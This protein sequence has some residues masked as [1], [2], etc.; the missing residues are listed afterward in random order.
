MK[1]IRLM[2]A[3]LVAV[4]M[5]SSF[6]LADVVTTANVNLRSGPGVSYDIIATIEPDVRL[7][8]LGE[9]CGNDNIADWYNVDY[10]GLAGWISAKYA[11]IVEDREPVILIPS[12][13]VTAEP[14]TQMEVSVFWNQG[15]SAAAKYVGLAGYQETLGELTKKYFN[16]YLTF[17]GNEKVQYIGLFGRGYTLF[18]ASVGMEI[19]DAAMALNAAGLDLLSVDEA[20]IVFGHRADN[21]SGVNVNGHDS[22]V[23]LNMKNGFVTEIEWS[24][25][26]G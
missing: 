14:L 3:L 24:A 21:T 5:V 25:Y 19:S 15:L 16:A 22:S 9:D 13:S 6:A 10:N 20:S 12:E 18:G 1:K 7:R 2:A 8:Y 11:E 4:L 26:T 23:V 17:S